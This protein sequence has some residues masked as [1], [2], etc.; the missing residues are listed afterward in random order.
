MITKEQLIEYDF[1][2]FYDPNE[3]MWSWDMD[4]IVY[5]IKKQILYSHCEVDGDMV[6]LCIVKDIE[7]LI[8]LIWFYFKIDIIEINNQ[9]K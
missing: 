9:N 8:E 7:K 1:K 6:K 4:Y 2:P 3:V 5:D